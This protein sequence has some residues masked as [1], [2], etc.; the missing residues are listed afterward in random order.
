VEYP[1]TTQSGYISVE[2]DM[3][4]GMLKG[5]F[6]F[7]VADDGRV[8]ICVNGISVIRFKPFIP[9]KPEDKE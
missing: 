2:E 5:E 7:Q 8:W 9:W 6:G 1:Q 3:R 4:A